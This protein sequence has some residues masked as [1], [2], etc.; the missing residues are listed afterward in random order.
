[1]T[2]CQVRELIHVRHEL[3]RLTAEGRSEEAQEMITRLRN[4]AEGDEEERAE[5][6][7]ELARWQVRLHPDW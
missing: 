5:T 6:E 7:T 3:R 4:L 2:Y 1:M